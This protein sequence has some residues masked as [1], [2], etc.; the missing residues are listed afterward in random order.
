M[1]MISKDILEKNMLQYIGGPAGSIQRGELTSSERFLFAKRK[2]H[3]LVTDG[4]E[5]Y[6]RL[7]KNEAT[8]DDS[9]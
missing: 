4:S 9:K 5:F 2:I 3:S 1:N 8:T 7:G 6:L